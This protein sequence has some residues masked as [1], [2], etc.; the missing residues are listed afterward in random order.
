MFADK[1][2][3]HRRRPDQNRNTAI[4][5]IE[6]NDTRSIV[7]DMNRPAD[8]TVAIDHGI[9]GLDAIPAAH[10]D[11][12]GTH[13]R[14]PSIGDDPTGRI[15]QRLFINCIQQCPHMAETAIHL[16]GAPLPLPQAFI[17]L[18]E[19][20]KLIMKGEISVAELPT[21]PRINGWQRR[22]TPGPEPPSRRFDHARR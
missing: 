8:E 2:R 9:A 19:A 12:H 14:P 5:I 10:I 7:A 13:E 6:Q 11:K 1:N 4:E 20:L 17:L 3:T 21:A 18:L 16:P 22:P 15:V